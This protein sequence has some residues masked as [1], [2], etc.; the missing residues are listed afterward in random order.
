VLKTIAG[1]LL[2]LP[3]VMFLV[4][5]IIFLL[6]LQLPAEERVVVYLPSTRSNL[7]PEDAANLVKVTI[8]RYGLDQPPAVQYTRWISNLLQGDWGYSPSWR[9][10]VLE[11]LL[12]RLPA[13]TE[14]I[15]FAMVPAVLLSI[16]LGSHAAYRRGRLPDHLIR[17]AI[18]IG[19]AFPSFILALILL[20]VFYAWNGWFPPERLSIWA[21]AIV[22]SQDFH[23][24]T[25]L[26]TVDALLN[27]NFPIY[28]DALRH[29][30]LPAF[31][32]A[33]IEWALLARLMRSSLLEVMEQ[34]YI[35]TARS[36]GLPE[37]RV[38]RVHARRNALL[39]VISIGGVAAATLI[40]TVCVV[41]VV[42]NF[43]GIGRGVVTAFQATE[44]PVTV[45]FALISCLVVLLASL[46]TDILYIFADPRIR[47]VSEESE[48]QH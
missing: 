1:R 42:F 20:N 33:L 44:I 15:L 8:E 46:F 3:V 5:L 36:K 19:W 18:F 23:S 4:T 26:L 9:Q 22:R 24:Y 12:Q 25:G 29:L 6:I 7:S 34:D 17:S 41:E 30:V 13:T 39:P 2:T 16:S 48:G 47:F 11:G 10:P 35:T 32:V 28:I 27:G 40:T 21:G 31:T 38:I 37:S 14:L 45:G 43:N